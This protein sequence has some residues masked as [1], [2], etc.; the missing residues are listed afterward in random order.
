M[1]Q[2]GSAPFIP[3]ALVVYGDG[4]ANP[5]PNGDTRINGADVSN[6]VPA[7]TPA[8]L[9]ESDG[10]SQPTPPFALPQPTVATYQ[11]YRLVVLVLELEV[12]LYLVPVLI[13]LLV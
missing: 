3:S 2:S 10:G 11:P 12:N 13:M 4:T 8:Y 6:V 5:A 9:I 7:Q 1:Q